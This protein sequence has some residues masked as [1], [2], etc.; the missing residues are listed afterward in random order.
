MESHDAV[1]GMVIAGLWW[2]IAVF[3]FCAGVLVGLSMVV[4]SGEY[5]HS[6]LAWSS[7]RRYTG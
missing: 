5:V 1:D 4:L 2:V 6:C 7:G 3:G